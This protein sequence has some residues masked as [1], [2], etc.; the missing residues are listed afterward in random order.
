[1]PLNQILT[2]IV[3]DDEPNAVTN[4]KNLL[5]QYCKSIEVIDSANCVESG[6]L[7]AC[8]KKPDV[9]FLDISMP[10]KSGF[11]LLNLIN[12]TPS[13]VFVTAHEKYALK[14]IKACAVDFLLKPIDIEE[15]KLVEEKLLQLKTLFESHNIKEDYRSS[16]SNLVNFLKSPSKLKTLTLADTNGYNIVAL[17]DI[18]YLAGHD[19]YTT[20][21]M[22]NNRKVVV[23]KTLKE[24]EQLLEDANFYRTHKSSMINLQH[25][26]GV[27]Q[28]DN[29]MAILSNKT[30]VIVSRRRAVQFIELTKQFLK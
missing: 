25:L 5:N 11:E 23:A 30:E 18:I 20:I 27:R 4:L 22:K 7:I 10:G 19:N 6:A 3:I 1:M 24:Y 14:A 17:E 16:V 28:Q 21:Y 12:Y 9:I 8:A 26:T 13:I 2:A 15:L 29:L